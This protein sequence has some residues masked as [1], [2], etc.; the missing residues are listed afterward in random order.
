[1]VKGIIELMAAVERMGGNRG[2]SGKGGSRAV[3]I[4][5]GK[6][7]CLRHAEPS[8][9]P[10]STITD[11]ARSSAGDVSIKAYKFSD[12]FAAALRKQKFDTQR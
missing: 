10:P 1:M 5:H 9:Y 4:V 6:R 8:S 2:S 7:V 3:L 11:A 12:G